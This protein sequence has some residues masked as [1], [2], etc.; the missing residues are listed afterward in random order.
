M[1]R[2]CARA[3]PFSPVRCAQVGPRR[4]AAQ[5]RA[6]GCL[7]A[8]R[9]AGRT[10]AAVRA[11]SR[12]GRGRRR[13]S[14]AI[15]PTISAGSIGSIKSTK[16]RYPRKSAIEKAKNAIHA[17][18][19]TSHRRKSPLSIA[20]HARLKPR[21]K[22]STAIASDAAAGLGWMGLARVG[23]KPGWDRGAHNDNTSSIPV[24]NDGRLEPSLVLSAW[25][26]AR[27]ASGSTER[28]E[29]EASL[30][31]ASTREHPADQLQPQPAGQKH[32]NGSAS[33][34][35]AWLR[36]PQMALCVKSLDNAQDLP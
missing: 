24:W 33:R 12:Q 22:A 30:R 36:H 17:A 10:A 26:L 28:C 35:H 14:R 11:L 34:P 20:P 4:A 7:A 31:T 23:L 13:S 18:L 5:S 27:R 16:C 1:R 8:R 21:A 32:P 3:Q 2:V 19:Y 29:R 9:C 6:H 25:F 15:S